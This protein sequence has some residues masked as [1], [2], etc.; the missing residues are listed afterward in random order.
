MSFGPIARPGRDPEREAQR[1]RQRFRAITRRFE[2]RSRKPAVLR[3]A[4]FCVLAAAIGFGGGLAAERF[5]LW[6]LLPL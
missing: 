5:D 6:R 2:W 4:A 3:W 1:L